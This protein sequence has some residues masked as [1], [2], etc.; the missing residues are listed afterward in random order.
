ML[1]SAS[2]DYLQEVLYGRCDQ[3]RLV[4]DLRDLLGLYYQPNETAEQRARHIALFVKDL[5]DMSQ[6][7]VDWAISDWRRNH[8][9]RPSP[10]SLRQLCMMRRH[11]AV[12][13]MGGGRPYNPPVGNPNPDPARSV[14]ER[15]AIV[16]RC[17]K[18]AGMVKHEGQW[19]TPALI[20][21]REQKRIPHWSEGAAPDDPRF[22][23][24]RRARIRAGIILSAPEP[25]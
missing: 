17:A 19:V 23:E 3:A 18:A 7:C 16:E 4:D 2:N 22:A 9:R 14:E 20:A 5:G 1:S 10:A 21:E 11:E 8:D 25:F 13:A 15:Q 12:K 24:L 6:D